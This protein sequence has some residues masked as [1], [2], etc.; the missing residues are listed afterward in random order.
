MYNNSIHER[1]IRDSNSSSYLGLVTEI[2]RTYEQ[3][4]NKAMIVEGKD[5]IR[6]YENYI[7][8]K[9]PGSSGL[10]IFAGGNK[11]SIL[12]FWSDIHSSKVNPQLQRIVS[13][14]KI[15]SLIDKDYPELNAGLDLSPK[16]LLKY[17]VFLTKV[18]SV[19][20]YFFIEES[21]KLV[22]KLINGLDEQQ[23]ERVLYLFKKFHEFIIKYEMYSI[24]RTI[25]FRKVKDRNHNPRAKLLCTELFDNSILQHSDIVF[26]N[27]EFKITNEILLKD[28]YSCAKV[29][30]R[31]ISKDKKFQRY[32]YLSQIGNIRAKWFKTVF[33]NYISNNVVKLIDFREI[34]NK[35][36]HKFD[37]YIPNELKNII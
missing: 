11:S 31:L 15:L 14:M 21:P 1:N 34:E 23:Y 3:K 27:D 18:H 30:N 28:Y 22:F 9:I 20:S 5:D 32:Q 4:N 29:A 26:D 7:K 35:H 25:S 6:I 37:I 8:N 17:K 33:Y 16:L 13:N 2:K 19:D 24:E 10:R 36:S 12:K